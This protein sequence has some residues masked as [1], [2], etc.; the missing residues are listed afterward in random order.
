MLCALLQ[1]TERWSDAD[2]P[3]WPRPAL[4][5]PRRARTPR[6]APR[7]GQSAADGIWCVCIYLIMIFSTQ[8]HTTRTGAITA[9][10]EKRS[11]LR[12]C[13]RDERA[14][15]TAVEAAKKKKMKDEGKLAAV[16]A[17]AAAK[18][19]AG[20]PIKHMPHLD[21]LE[22]IAEG[23][24]V[25]AYN[26]TKERACDHMHLDAYD[27]SRIERALAEMKGDAPPSSGAQGT[28]SPSTS[29]LTGKKCN[30]IE[31]ESSRTA[32]LQSTS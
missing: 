20:K 11:G 22:K 7:P 12:R 14:A 30:M 27:L 23:F 19:E 15:N 3:M 17:A 9:A 32:D 2:D 6:D 18:V 16:A 10:C 28:P 4:R 13:T 31:A 29:A 5:L 24:V 8:P 21:F 26:S 25:E 1:S